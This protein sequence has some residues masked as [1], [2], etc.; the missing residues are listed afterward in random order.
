MFPKLLEVHWLVIRFVFV[1]H[2]WLVELAMFENLEKRLHERVLQCLC[3]SYRLSAFAD[4]VWPLYRFSGSH[5]IVVR[6][7]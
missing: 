7:S 4:V 1:L 3:P 2:I 5:Q 6:G